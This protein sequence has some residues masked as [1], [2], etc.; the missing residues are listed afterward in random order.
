MADRA[1]LP[2]TAPPPIV[3]I[4]HGEVEATWK[5]ICYGDMD[6]PLSARGIET[7]LAV[8]RRI[9]LGPAPSIVFHSGLARTEQL[10]QMIAAF[11][12]T[13]IRVV[14]DTRLRERC[15][16]S[17]QGMSWDDAF[18]SDPDHFQDLIDKPDTYRPPQGETTPQMQS[19]IAEWWEEIRQMHGGGK[20]GPQRDGPIIAISHSGPIA[21]LAGHLLKLPANR[22]QAW[23]L[24]YLESLHVAWEEDMQGVSGL[25]CKLRLS[26]SN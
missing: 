3:I 4:R 8:A 2:S 19:R 22:W 26:Q 7:S 6:V 10:A 1:P 12:S 21:A 18:A 5:S 13:E 16:G 20:D 17:W 25:A 23:M 14:K 24:A 15:F 11:C 9:A